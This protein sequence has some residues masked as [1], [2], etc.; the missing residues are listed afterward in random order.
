MWKHLLVTIII[1]DIS[2]KN[3]ALEIY[4]SFLKAKF[5]T[6]RWINNLE[7]IS[8]KNLHKIDNLLLSKENKA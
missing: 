3:Q 6:V 4:Q 2:K 5:Q 1:K 7:W 8:K